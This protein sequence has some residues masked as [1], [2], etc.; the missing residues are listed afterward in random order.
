MTTFV[1][2]ELANGSTVAATA[3]FA[4]GTP[5]RPLGADAVAAK[6]LETCR[7]A[8]LAGPRIDAV[9]DGV[10]DLGGVADVRTLTGN[11]I[12]EEGAR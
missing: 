12:P 5:S 7:Y 10:R 2:L 3:D 8:G 1:E 9:V 11:L 6:F 4:R